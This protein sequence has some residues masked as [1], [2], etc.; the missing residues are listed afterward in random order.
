MA[1]HVL[2]NWFTS[3]IHEALNWTPSRFFWLLRALG[4]YL[5]MFSV[6]RISLEMFFSV[7]NVAFFLEIF[8]IIFAKVAG[9]GA[10]VKRFICS[11]STESQQLISLH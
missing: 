4:K 11:L 9:L 8:F 5:A 6:L 1:K 2:L 7:F 10:F 3:L